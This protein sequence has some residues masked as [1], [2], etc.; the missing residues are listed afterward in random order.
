M[1]GSRQTNSPAVSPGNSWTGEPLIKSV[2]W[3]CGAR[4]GELL[5]LVVDK[6]ARFLLKD[7]TCVPCNNLVPYFTM[8]CVVVHA[9]ISV[10]IKNLCV[11]SNTMWCNNK[12]TVFH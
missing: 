12:L 1:F 9:G 4:V 3:W 11:V 10:A 6:G 7:Y 8:K 5:H 2:S